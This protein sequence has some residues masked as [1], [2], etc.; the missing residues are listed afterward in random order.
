MNSSEA[1]RFLAVS[2]EEFSTEL[3]RA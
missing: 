3:E 1:L 2:A